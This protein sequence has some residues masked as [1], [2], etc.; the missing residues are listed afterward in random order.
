MGCVAH[1][2][3]ELVT[4]ARADTAHGEVALRRRGP[5]LE[6]VV[7]GAFA[8]D[9]VDTSTEVELARAALAGHAAPDRVLVGGLGLGFTARAVLADPRVGRLDVVE[10][11]AP[12]VAWAREGLVAELT[13]LE[14]DGRCRLWAGDVAD[15]L[16]PGRSDTAPDS[17]PAGPW[18]LVLLDVDNGPGFLV[19]PH[20]EQLYSDTGL[21]A[22]ARALTPAGVLVVWSSHPAPHLL[23]RLDAL[24]ER[25][26]GTSR[27]RLLTVER[28]GRAFEYA[29][30]ELTTASP[31]DRG[32]GNTGTT[33]RC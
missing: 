16:A 23:A 17:R 12:L 5:V 7:D 4:L 14:S 18:D 6:L 26:G 31:D 22:A 3:Q 2:P 25:D 9:T 1:P 30:Y 11:A 15:V 21:E 8:M 19:H 27:E 33:S 24:A 28:E 32:G 20:N 29:L 13:G 10:L